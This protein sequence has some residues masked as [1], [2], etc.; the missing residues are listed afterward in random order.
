[1]GTR[2]LQFA[3]GVLFLIVWVVSVALVGFLVRH[4]GTLRS[5]ISAATLLTATFTQSLDLAFHPNASEQRTITP[6]HTIS[7]THTINP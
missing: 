1:M 7:T 5:S 6:P 2:K 3:I 4:G